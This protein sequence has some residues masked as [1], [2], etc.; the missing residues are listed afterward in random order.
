M[1]DRLP[2]VVVRRASSRD[3]L[4]TCRGAEIWL[5]PSS[6]VPRT[7]NRGRVV[8]SALYVNERE[9]SARF[10]KGL[11]GFEI[12]TASEGMY[13]LSIEGKQVLLLFRKGASA[14]LTSPPP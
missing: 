3:A 5:C 12:I 1:P 6:Q 4:R 13:A 7:P 8:E 2:A 10:Y 14:H 11:L 9:R